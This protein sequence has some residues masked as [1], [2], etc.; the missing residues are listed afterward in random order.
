MGKYI[1]PKCKLCR[2]EGMKLYLKGQKCETKC[3]LE[4][5]PKPPG[6]SRRRFRIK[7]SDYGM[8]LR[9]KQKVRRIYGILEKQFR[10]YIAK[11]GKMKGV[12][13]ENLLSLL[14]R[15]LDNVVYRLGFGLSRAAARQ[16]VR[17]GLIRVNGKKV[18]IPSFLVSVDDIVEVKEKYKSKKIF[19]DYLESFDE[20]NV[21]KWLK[22]NKKALRGTVTNLP[23]RDDINLDIQEQ[24]IVEY[25]SR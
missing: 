5:R 15:R 25:Y 22:L 6:D 16:I 7:L 8:Q 2:R 4:K 12:K 21:P 3:T 11:A 20:N 17:H 18:D 14:E 9:E 19:A 13:G 1:G 23:V 24:L 10:T